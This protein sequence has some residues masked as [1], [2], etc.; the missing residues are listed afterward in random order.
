MKAN[1]DFQETK[2]V[3]YAT[4]QD[5][6][7]KL[8]DEFSFTCDVCATDANAKCASYFTELDNGLIQTWSGSC[9]CNPPYGRGLSS[10]IKK[11]YESSLMG[12]TV[13]CLVPSRTD[14]KWF[15]DYC[16]PYAEIRFVRGRLK[17]GG[18]KDPAPFPCAVVIFPA[19]GVNVTTDRTTLQSG[20]L[21]QKQKT[22]LPLNVGSDSAGNMPVQSV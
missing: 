14:T 15:Q 10:W 13:V 20:G 8:D 19:K 1:P 12:A 7:D 2:T 21:R 3:V 6:W 5:F 11:A 16:L 9:W 22:G 17:F 4:P 18:C